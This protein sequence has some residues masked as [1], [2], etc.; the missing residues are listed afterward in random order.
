MNDKGKMNLLLQ[1]FTHEIH[2]NFR[3]C[4]TFSTENFPKKARIF[5]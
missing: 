2:F 3:I 5:Y 1:N 4:I